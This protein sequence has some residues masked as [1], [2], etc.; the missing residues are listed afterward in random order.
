MPCLSYFILIHLL[1]SSHFIF[2]R[3]ISL[4]V[5]DVWISYCNKPKNISFMTWKSCLFLTHIKCII[6]KICATKKILLQMDSFVNLYT[7]YVQVTSFS[8]TS[9]VSSTSLSSSP[10]SLNVL[11][12]C[13]RHLFSELICR[14]KRA[15]SGKNLSHS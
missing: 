11:C 15:K 6:L 2:I 9:V 13:C 4:C 10:A 3:F 12:F 1:F 7:W 14:P 8:L 5:T